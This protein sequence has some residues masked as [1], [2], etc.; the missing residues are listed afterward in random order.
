MPGGFGVQLYLGHFNQVCLNLQVRYSSN[1]YP[2][3]DVDRDKGTQLQVRKNKQ[4]ICTLI[5]RRNHQKCY[6][7]IFLFA[8]FLL[9]YRMKNI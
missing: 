6:K 2:L 5:P 7:N 1:S 4:V 9:L 8:P 3:E